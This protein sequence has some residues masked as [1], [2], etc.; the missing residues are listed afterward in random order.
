MSRDPET[1]TSCGQ[2]TQFWLA[3][4]NWNSHCLRGLTP[5]LFWAFRSTLL[6]TPRGSLEA[7]ICAL[8][9]SRALR[10]GRP[11]ELD[12]TSALKPVHAVRGRLLSTA[13][14]QLPDLSLPLPSDPFK[15]LPPR[16]AFILISPHTPDERGLEGDGNSTQNILRIPLPAAVPAHS[17]FFLYNILPRAVP[18]ARKRLVGGEDVCVACPTGNN[19]GPGVIVAALSLFFNDGGDLICGNDTD[20]KGRR[21]RRN[22]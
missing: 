4:T 19:L 2:G 6:A 14:S 22:I 18:F 11:T 8:A 9:G 20:S 17:N 7:V 15:S 3:Q 5:D 16:L 10:E 1:T 12:W 21:Y 13:I